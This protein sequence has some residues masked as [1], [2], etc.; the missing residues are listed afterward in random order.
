META[1]SVITS[2]LLIVFALTTCWLSN[3]E[4]VALKSES[5]SKAPNTKYSVIIMPEGKLN[6]HETTTTTMERVNSTHLNNVCNLCEDVTNEM[7]ELLRSKKTQKRIMDILHGSC[8]LFFNLK[9][10]CMAI[11]NSYGLAFFEIVQIVQPKVICH[12]I[13]LC[14][15]KPA[16]STT[17]FMSED[18]CEVCRYVVGKALTELKYPNKQLEI[19]NESVLKT[20]ITME[21]NEEKCKILIS[22][23]AR[24][25][26]GNTKHFLEAMDLCAATRT[27]DSRSSS[28]M[29]N[30]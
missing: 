15:S 3:A 26:M 28:I 7:L 17:Y 12:S 13:H 11:V 4:Q 1:L 9:Q 23:Y 25:I 29:T 8:S 30:R 5:Y 16:N 21:G 18:R 24:M 20:C 2:I 27:C 10:K 22:E 19:I 6:T 14:S